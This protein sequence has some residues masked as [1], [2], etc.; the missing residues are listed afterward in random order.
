MYANDRARRNQD[1]RETA[2]ENHVIKPGGVRLKASPRLRVADRKLRVLKPPPLEP[3][4]AQLETFVH[5]LFPYAGN[6]GYVSIRSFYDDGGDKSFK[7]KTIKLADGGGLTA[8]IECAMVIARRA[9]NARKLIVFSPPVAVFSSESGWQARQVDLLLG[10]TISVEVDKNAP[11]ALATLEQLLGP[12]TVT[13]ASGGEWINP[14]TGEVQPKLH[15][16]WRL[17]KPASDAAALDDLKKA[18]ELATELVGGDPSHAPI[19]H[20]I[21]WP[22]SWHRKKTPKL[23]RIVKVNPDVEIDL[24]EALRAL[25]EVSPDGAGSNDD[26]AARFEQLWK[27]PDWGEHIALVQSGESYHTPLLK[28]AAKLVVSG[29]NPVAAENLLRGLM[30]TADDSHDAR[31]QARVND[32]GRAVQSAVNNFGPK[33]EEKAQEKRLQAE[34][35]KLAEVKLVPVDLWERSGAPRLP[36]GF[37]P[38]V[39]EEFAV[40]QSELMGAD[41]AGLAM[42]ALAVCLAV[43]PDCI[44]LQP[45]RHD[46]GWTVPP[47]LWVGLVGGVGAM[48]TPIT[49]E[50]IRPVARINKQMWRVYLAEKEAYDNMS[51]EERKG[52]EK[53]KCTL[54][55]IEDATSE[56]AQDILANSPDGVLLFR[57]ELS[58]WFGNMD[59][60]AGRRGAGDGERGFWLQAYNGGAYDLHR[61]GRGHKMIDPLSISVLGGIQ[62][63]TARAIVGEGID[64]GLIQRINP[65]MLRNGEVGSDEPIS[66]VAECYDALVGR[67]HHIRR[68]FFGVLQFDDDAQVVRRQVEQRY[69]DFAV[70]YEKVSKKFSEHVRKYHGMFARY[71]LLWHCIEHHDDKFPSNI[72]GETAHRVATFMH[73]FLLPHANAFYTDMLGLADNHDQLL[74]VAGY[75]LAHKLER[76]TNRDVARGTRS[77]RDLDRPHIE[78]IFNQLDTFG[79]INRVPSRKFN[80][81]LHG[82]VNQAV[83]VRFANYAEK[84]KERRQRV[85]AMIAEM[86]R[87]NKEHE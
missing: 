85:A 83:H 68:Q 55:K 12:A 78:R 42:G 75:I 62:P 86:N 6:E 63:D 56:G 23:C 57:D 24:A 46:L 48:K 31:W 59:K 9:A 47:I 3:D 22:G 15:G 13:V 84:E 58:G 87:S 61:V 1:R 54:V 41:P 66:P 4:R 18:R 40:V 14:E 16:H 26:V 64:D 60:Y 73:E 38:T 67:L 52:V 25:Q 49:S 27:A 36:M 10:L 39:I 76:I 37:L 70:G 5:A 8:I 81:P 43:I 74:D 82:V 51:T 2:N 79:W 33:A 69:H 19:S 45:K 28:L 53:P 17:A 77:M 72:D 44:R 71:C 34:A 7:I 29:M 80:D 11:Q 30:E 35:K 65:I 32:I 20:P 50:V 21:R